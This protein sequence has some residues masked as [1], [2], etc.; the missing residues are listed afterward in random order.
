MS[1]CGAGGIL[2][3]RRVLPVLG[4]LAAL[5]AW[6]QYPG[7]VAKGGKDHPELRAIAVLEWTGEEENPKASRLVPVVVLDAG[8]LQ[9]GGI[10]LARPE[11]LA[12]APEVEYELQQNGKAVGLFDLHGSGRQQGSWVGFGSWKPMP[13]AQ[14]KPSPQQ[15]AQVGMDNQEGD[16]PTL[17]RKH[18]GKD[19]P[20]GGAGNGGSSG[21]SG[22]GSGSPAP[23]SDP[24]RPTLHK[25]D[26]GSGT[27]DTNAS[28][29]TGDATSTTTGSGT[30]I[31]RAS[32]RE[33]V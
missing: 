16:R 23:P 17:H 11:P 4:L 12:L 28:P 7:Q 25:K 26:S 31:G 20:A 2:M 24:D 5:P 27:S 33:R 32:C 10:Y 13:K 15:L 6:A 21:S 14:P 8:Q 22:A 9:D 1:L 3:R 30:E 29:G 18:H 19:E